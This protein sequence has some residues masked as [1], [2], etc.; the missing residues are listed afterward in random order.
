MSTN[1]G[2]INVQQKRGASGGGGG[3]LT[4]ANNGTSLDVGGTIVQLGQDVG[5]VGNPAILLNDREIPMGGFSFQ[6]G[7]N[8]DKRFFVD[9]TAGLY[10]FGDINA[11]L[12]NMFLQI[13]DTLFTCQ[14]GDI[15]QVNNKTLFK[16][17]DAAG[18]STI[19]GSVV[20]LEASSPN[21]PLWGIN[22]NTS[23]NTVQQGLALNRAGANG[24]IGMGI[25]ILTNMNDA[26]GI[27][28]NSSSIDTIW[29]DPTS[30]TLT[31]NLEFKLRNTAIPLATKFSLYGTGDVR[32]N[33]YGTGAFSAVP[34]FMLGVDASGFII[35]V[36]GGGAG[37]AGADNGL[38]LDAGGTIAELGQD[39]GAVGDPGI[40]LNDREIPMGGFSFAMQDAGNRKFLIDNANSLY[41]FGDIDLSNNGTQLIIDDAS[42]WIKAMNNGN[43]YLSLD[44]AGQD[45]ALGDYSGATNGV[46]WDVRNGA[47]NAIQGTANINGNPGSS[48]FS[49]S[50]A[51]NSYRIGDLN[52]RLNHSLFKIDDANQVV[53]IEG[54]GNVYFNWD[55]NTRQFSIGDFSAANNN[56]VFNADDINQKFTMTS[57]GGVGVGGIATNAPSATGSGLWLLG[58][59][60]AAVSVLDATQYV[61]AMIDGVLYKLALAV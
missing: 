34:A 6:L 57:V 20:G 4:G 16:I 3:T 8:A 51:T 36:A 30:L 2:S 31:S 56:T 42:E 39:V 40:L 12:N 28:E 44:I 48:V 49:I 22:E 50:G 58:K 43:I 54:S 19:F 55:M 29:T 18:K 32:L 59:K 27:L 23:T 46:L 37:L 24:A 47:A 33:D 5:A 14:L 45:Y 10:Q 52:N 61:E 21:L 38:S 53:T 7:G 26:S 41:E 9:P 15:N 60:V 25:Q 13:N 35:E 1:Q 11:A 17:L